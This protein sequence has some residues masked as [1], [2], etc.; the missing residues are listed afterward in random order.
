[1][2]KN[3]STSCMS[4]EEKFL[5]CDPKISSFVRTI[6]NSFKDCHVCSGYRD[7]AD[8]HIAYVSGKSTFDWPDSKHNF[9]L[10]THG[11]SK[12][13]DLFMLGTDGKAYFL[14][15]YY[16]SIWGYYIANPQNF[17]PEKIIWGGNWNHLHDLDHW[18]VE[19]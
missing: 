14:E 13:C 16:K 6:Q 18:E 7:Q 11:Y 12:A 1:M 3:P 5:L 2:H 17:G 10:Y 19:D 15:E 8:Q 4:C 9:T